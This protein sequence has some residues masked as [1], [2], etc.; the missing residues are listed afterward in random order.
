MAHKCHGQVHWDAACCFLCRVQRL[1]R[2]AIGS[3]DGRPAN[4]L[5]TPSEGEI[6]VAHQC[7]T[8]HQKNLVASG[9][10]SKTHERS[11]AL[12]KPVSMQKVVV[13]VQGQSQ[14]VIKL[15]V[16]GWEQGNVRIRERKALAVKEG[17]VGL[18]ART[19]ATA[20]T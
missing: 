20:D 2:P 7:V 1:N 17:A 13:A 15:E 14:V 18:V 12:R 4:S 11:I 19:C 10:D 16:Q 9:S 8:Q 6:I 5:V 3:V